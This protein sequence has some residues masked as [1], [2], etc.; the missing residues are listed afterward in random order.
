MSH[1]DAARRLSS[2]GRSCQPRGRHRCFVDDVLRGM[3]QQAGGEGRSRPLSEAL[4]RALRRQLGADW[5]RM[6]AQFN[7]QAP[8]GSPC[9][10][11]DGVV[12][13]PVPV[14][15]DGLG[16]VIEVGLAPGQVLADVHWQA[17]RRA[18][19]VWELASE[20]DRKGGSV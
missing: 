5:V 2:G 20:F 18:I 15:G 11:D 17:I 19:G 4:E 1:S 10:A 9:H 13:V 7:K 8:G 12:R 16:W 6:R 3:W 14:R